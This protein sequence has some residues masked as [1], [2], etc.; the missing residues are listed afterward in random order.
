MKKKMHRCKNCKCL[1]EFCRKVKKHEYCNKKECQRARK[2][3][4]QKEKLKNDKQYCTDQK[5][6]QRDWVKT[7]PEYW[8]EYR[9]NHPEYTRQNRIKQRYR[10]EMRRKNL[11]EKKIAKMDALSQEC[12]VISGRYMLIPTTSDK[13]AK[14]D[15]IVVEINRI[16]D[17]CAYSG[18]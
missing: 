18:P 1:F 11:P 12:T 13:I 3:R 2:R 5:Q 17:I 7:N 6:A 14:M 4:W 9:E 15:A 8:K 16:S 10:N